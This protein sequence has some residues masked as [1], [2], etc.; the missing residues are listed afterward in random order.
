MG[1]LLR[2]A[3]WLRARPAAVLLAVALVIGLVLT[4]GPRPDGVLP[5]PNATIGTAGGT[6]GPTAT[7]GSP[8]PSVEGGSSATF[9]SASPSSPTT[10]P[11]ATPT[12]T[13]KPTSKPTPKP[14]SRPT[15]FDPSRVKLSLDPFLSGLSR[16]VYLTGA[17]DGT[18]DLYVVEQ[19]GVI[20]RVHSGA[21]ST[22]LDIR[23]PVNDAGNEQGLLSVAFHP[24]YPANG[25]LFVFYTGA[26]GTLTISEFARQGA[27]AAD[28]GSEQVILEIPHPSYANHN[29]G[30]LKFGPDGY[31]YIGTGD[32][33]SGG[34][35]S[36]NAQ[37]PDVLLGKLLRIDVDG[38]APYDVPS[39]NPFVGRSGWRP[40]IWALGLRNPW[41]WSFDRST[42]DLFIGDVGQ[43]AWEEIDATRHGID[44]RNYGWR[45]MEG[46]HCYNASSCSKTGL[47]L[48]AVEYGHGSGDCA[49]V[50]GYVY[51]GGTA[52]LKGGYLFGDSCSGRIWAVRASSALAGSVKPTLI[53]DTSL[54][55]SSFGESDT[56]TLYVIDLGGSIF[57]VV[58][59]SR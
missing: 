20:K 54:S 18:G 37:S 23:G 31:L 9:S 58:A 26:A 11:A 10:E 46:R 21:V 55:I 12:P 1:M 40:E 15:G 43:N 19:A 49:V 34:D 48:P 45:R 30:L 28:P 36:N 13:P 2:A 52:I 53:R 35:P 44:G 4:A 41:R 50:G 47:T 57:R 25:R 56:G 59:S 14:T 39:G 27:A 51:R 29:G 8:T 22:F 38:S 16:P 5:A 17:G 7:S 6:G 3:T 32:G 33:G 24:D 42:G